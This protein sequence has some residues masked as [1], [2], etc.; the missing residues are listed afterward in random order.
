MRL[1]VTNKSIMFNRALGSVLS[2]LRGR[3]GMTQQEVADILGRTKQTISNYEIGEHNINLCAYEMLVLAELFGIQPEEFFLR[4]RTVL[5]ALEA[6]ILLS[7][8]RPTSPHQT[9]NDGDKVHHI[10]V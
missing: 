8:A 3:K 10:S 2:S 4:A 7:P 5:K 6:P 1:R 9:V